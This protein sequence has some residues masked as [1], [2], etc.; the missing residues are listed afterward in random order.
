MNRIAVEIPSPSKVEASIEIM[1]PGRL[2]VG[3]GNAFVLRGYCYYPA[4]GARKLAIGVAGARQPVGNI[5]LPRDNDYQRFDPKLILT[6]A[7]RTDASV[8]AGSIQAYPKLT[9]P[10]DVE[11]LAG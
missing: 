7:S 11:A 5:R 3:R 9:R 1:P 10:Q 2:A 8:P 6:L 4:G